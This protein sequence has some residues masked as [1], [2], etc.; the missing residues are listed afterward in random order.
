MQ[1]DYLVSFDCLGHKAK[2]TSYS[3]ASTE[4]R[5]ACIGL[6]LRIEGRDPAARRYWTRSDTQARTA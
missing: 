2:N 3:M 4:E 1:V 6:R 5:T